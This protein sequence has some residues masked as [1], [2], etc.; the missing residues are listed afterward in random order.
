LH[1]FEENLGKKFTI[2]QLNDYLMSQ[3]VMKVKSTKVGRNVVL[4]GRVVRT[5]TEQLANTIKIIT[6]NTF[7]N[8]EVLTIKDLNYLKYR[9]FLL[10]SYFEFYRIKEESKDVISMKDMAKIFISYINIYKNKQILDKLNNNKYDLKGDINFKQFVC[11]FWFCSDFHAIK[12]MI[13][14]KKKVNLQQFVE[15]ANKALDKSFPD[16]SKRVKLTSN[17]MKI[18][19]EILDTDK[20]GLLTYEEIEEIVK[21]RDFFNTKSEYKDLKKELF[22]FFGKLFDFLRSNFPSFS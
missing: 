1:V 19:F 9:L 8:K 10:L 5:D 22:V 7:K 11:F 3:M 12:E 14:E 6:K 17:E 21:R 15:I 20:N 16:P 13:I 4:D 2:K 18:V